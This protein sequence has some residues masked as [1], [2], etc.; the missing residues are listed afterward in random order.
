VDVPVAAMRGPDDIDEL[1]RRFHGAHQRRYGHMAQDETIEIVN[2]KVTGIGVIPKPA[3]QRFAFG[4][5]AT[6]TP[7]ETRTG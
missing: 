5:G 7:H 1:A 6:P 2:F 3:L 4:S